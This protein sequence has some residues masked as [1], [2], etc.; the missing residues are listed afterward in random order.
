M[1]PTPPDWTD[2]ALCF[3]FSKYTVPAK[4]S[5]FVEGYLDFLPDYYRSFA[6]TNSH[7][8]HAVAAVSLAAFSVHTGLNDLMQSARVA[9]GR[10][11]RR[12]RVA[13]SEIESTQSDETLLTLLLFCKYEV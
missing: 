3:F 11:L 12:L 1:H 5:W 13:L 9:Y 6:D 4:S 7:V 2:Q 10:S 8:K